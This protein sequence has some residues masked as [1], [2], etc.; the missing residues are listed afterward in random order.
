LTDLVNATTAGDC[1]SV[2]SPV[3][4]GRALRHGAGRQ[5]VTPSVGS[6]P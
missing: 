4:M 2:I 5:R 3:L 1:M 6:L